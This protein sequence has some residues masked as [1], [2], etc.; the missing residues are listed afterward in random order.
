MRVEGVANGDDD[1]CPCARVS[2][3]TDYLG[4]LGVTWES[5]DPALVT[6]AE[7]CAHLTRCH[8]LSRSHSLQINSTCRLSRDAI[9]FCADHFH[10]SP[11]QPSLHATSPHIFTTEPTSPAALRRCAPLR[12]L[13]PVLPPNCALTC[14]A[15]HHRPR[16]H[17]CLRSHLCLRTRLLRHLRHQPCRRHLSF[18]RR[19]DSASFAHSMSLPTQS[20]LRLN[21]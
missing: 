10:A 5:P 3:V 1:E 11:N 19:R 8:A 9:S 13:T 15:R 7:V 21:H 18:P 4:S 20:L 6:G 17:H 14:P 12:V 16:R 2:A